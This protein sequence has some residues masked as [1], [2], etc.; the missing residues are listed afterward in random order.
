MKR[1]SIFLFLSMFILG[2]VSTLGFFNTKS[3]RVYAE[4]TSAS[5]WGG[6]YAS[7]VDETDFYTCNGCSISSGEVHQT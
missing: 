6:T 3:E 4:S 1:K 7:E 5:T 2:V